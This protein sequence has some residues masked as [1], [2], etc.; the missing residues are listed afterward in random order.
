MPG[1]LQPDC[2][3]RVTAARRIKTP[4]SEGGLGEDLRIPLVADLTHKMSLD[5]G[6]MLEDVGHTLRCVRG[7]RRSISRGAPAACSSLTG[8]AFCARS[9]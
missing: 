9:R 4:R 7:Q 2:D 3:T 8:R 6:V 1:A 5:Y